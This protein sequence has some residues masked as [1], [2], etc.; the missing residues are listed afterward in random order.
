MAENVEVHRYA[1]GHFILV[2]ALGFAA[3]S[4]P[5]Q[6]ARHSGDTDRLPRVGSQPGAIDTSALPVLGRIEVN[7]FEF[8]RKDVGVGSGRERN[9]PA[10]RSAISP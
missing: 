9:P 3:F 2:L 4:L 7:A 10:Y 1:V 8:G 6:G 5:Q